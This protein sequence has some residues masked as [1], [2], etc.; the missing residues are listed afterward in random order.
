MCVASPKSFGCS[1]DEIVCQRRATLKPSRHTYS[2][3]AADLR[4]IDGDTV[5]FNGKRFGLVRFDPLETSR[6]KRDSERREVSK[7]RSVRRL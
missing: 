2:I 6:E 4:V 5:F 3:S 1:K 7:Q